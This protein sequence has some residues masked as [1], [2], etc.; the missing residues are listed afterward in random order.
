MNGA[1]LLA[2]FPA[3]VMHDNVLAGY[4]GKSY[5]ANND[6]PSTA[7]F[8][9]YFADFAGADYHVLATAPLGSDG[10]RVGADVS[11]L[12]SRK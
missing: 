9:S 7:T 2:A 11:R 1:G 8:M 12:P 3:I 10:K 5:P 6:Y 4:T